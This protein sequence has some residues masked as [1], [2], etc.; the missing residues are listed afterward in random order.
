MSKPHKHCEL[1]KAWA[2]GAPI[3][4]YSYNTWCTDLNPT[5]REDRQ[6]RIKPQT[7]LDVAIEALEEI[8][9]GAGVGASFACIALDKIRS[10]E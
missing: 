2:D 7:K 9:N 10:M 4:V 1:I 5:W 8:S 6:Y 3:E